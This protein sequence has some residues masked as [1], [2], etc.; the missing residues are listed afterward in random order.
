M[1]QHRAIFGDLVLVLFSRQ[2]VIRVDV[3]EP[4]KDTPDAGLRHLLDKVR[5]AVTQ[6]IDLDRKGELQIM[7]GAHRDQA[8]G[9]LL[10]IAVARK[11]VVGD[12]E[13][14]DAAPVM[15]VD[16][17]F[18]IVRAAVAALPALHVDDRAE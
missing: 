12:E 18:E 11:I 5:D 17:A 1:L 14:R 13:P 2:Q 4:D 16:A 7:G 9:Q 8:V 3:F 15:L 10:P 6:R